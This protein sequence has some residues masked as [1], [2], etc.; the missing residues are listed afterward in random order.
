MQYLH[1]CLQTICQECKQLNS[2]TFCGSVCKIYTFMFFFLFQ[3]WI[4]FKR[5]F[6]NFKTACIPWERKIKEVESMFLLQVLL[7]S[8][9]VM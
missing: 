9:L 2:K 4:K 8:S 7:Q 5:D 6:D 3:K 1:C